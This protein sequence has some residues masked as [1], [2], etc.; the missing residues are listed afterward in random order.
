MADTE[1]IGRTISPVADMQAEPDLH[2]QHDATFHQRYDGLTV[3]RE[4]LIRRF[5]EVR[6]GLEEDE[7][8]TA[9]QQ[10]DE[11]AVLL[12]DGNHYI[13]DDEL[14]AAQ[15]GGGRRAA[16][17]LNT[18]LRSSLRGKELE[19]CKIAIRVYADFSNL[20][21]TAHRVGLALGPPYAHY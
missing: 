2:H 20:S 6:A 5:E 7:L 1:S 18:T 9:D 8:W 4:K 14:I 10:H 16:R 21:K 13:F 12:V 15:P 11:Y 17:L 19:H 3:E